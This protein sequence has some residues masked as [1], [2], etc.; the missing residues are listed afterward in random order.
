MRNLSQRL[1]AT[2]LVAMLLTGATAS[3]QTATVQLRA[4][5]DTYTD[6]FT[7]DANYGGSLNMYMG[8]RFPQAGGQTM[9]FVQF[10]LGELPPAV[11]ILHAELWLRKHEKQGAP[12]QQVTLAAHL[13]TTPGWSE[14]AVTHNARPGYATVA[15]ATVTSTFNPPGW[16]TFVVTPDVIAAAAAG[17]DVGWALRCAP[18]VQNVWIN[19][20]TS[21]HV[22]MPDYRPMLEITY[23][24][25]VATEAGP[26]GSVKALYR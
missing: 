18:T 13:V 26:F 4:G 14:M 9:S 19:L 21:E 6:S 5:D 17:Q 15:T 7:P 2:A 8:D 12:E 25:T 1:F 23:S 20:Y 11:E 10:D 24:G 3:G 16:A 22:P